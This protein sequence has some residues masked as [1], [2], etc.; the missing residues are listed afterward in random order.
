MAKM[1]GRKYK[2]AAM[3]SEN[4]GKHREIMSQFSRGDINY[5]T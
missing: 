4:T 5:L 1:L 2:A 3:T